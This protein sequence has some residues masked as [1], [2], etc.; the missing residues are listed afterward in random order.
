M[1]LN[2]ALFR[3]AWS[4]VQVNGSTPDGAF[5]FIGN[6]GNAK[7]DGIEVEMEAQP[8]EGL[9]LS[10][11]L[12]VLDARLSTDQIDEAGDFRSA[13]L[14]GI[15][16]HACL[17]LRSV[18]LRSISFRSWMRLMVIS[19]STFPTQAV[20]LLSFGTTMC[21]SSD[22]RITRLLTP[23]LASTVRH[24]AHRFTRPICSIRVPRATEAL[25]P[26]PT[27]RSLR[28]VRAPSV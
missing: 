26:L 14:Q 4:D 18:P 15:E 5:A 27:V 28:F 22:L 16:F 3:M 12:T 19:V 6:A 13:G 7:V 11:G 8:V 20:R 25:M 1:T 9:Y 10:G 24:G 2:A 23:G 17:S 21:F